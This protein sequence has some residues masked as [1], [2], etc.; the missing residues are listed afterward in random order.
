MRLNGG[1]V[2][3]RWSRH[4]RYPTERFHPQHRQAGADKWYIPR[5][6]RHPRYPPWCS[7]ALCPANL[8]A[9]GR[10]A[11]P[12][13]S[14]HT[15][16]PS[17]GGPAPQPTPHDPPV[18][19]SNSWATSTLIATNAIQH[20]RCSDRGGGRSRRGGTTLPRSTP[21]D[22]PRNPRHPRPRG[23]HR[24]CFLSGGRL[25]SP[26]P[27]MIRT[28]ESRSP[29]RRAGGRS[30]TSYQFEPKKAETENQ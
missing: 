18:V 21:N 10:S 20:R 13:W 6:S 1:V 28:A 26:L 16:Y 11:P 22:A 24:H 3:S 2:S 17:E 8:G 5:R 23:F 30:T 7:T 19:S 29:H 14:R 15:R 9:A 12:Q 4:P 25:R 27:P